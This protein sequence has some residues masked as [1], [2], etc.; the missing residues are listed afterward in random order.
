MLALTTDFILIE[1]ASEIWRSLSFQ[2]G[3]NA[4]I[5]T[6]GVTFLGAA[7]GL[8]GCFTV[9]RKRA[10]MSDALAH[11]ALPG[12]ALTFIIV[13]SLGADARNLIVLLLGA[14]LSASLGIICVQFISRK[15][16]LTE[17]SA[18]GAVLSVFFGAGIV[19]LSYIQNMGTAQAAGLQTFIYGQ[20]AALRLSDMFLTICL[21]FLAVA[22]CVLLL[23]EFRLVCFDPEFA[24]SQGW[25]VNLIDLIM[26]GL[27]ILII[28]IGLQSVGL[29]LIV[30]LLVIPPATARFWTEDLKVMLVIS[31]VCGALSAYIGTNLSTIIP[32]LP[33]GAVIVVSAG[34]LF[35][36]SL[37][38][39]PQRG[40][41]ATALRNLALR[42]KV[43][44]DHILRAAYEIAEQN[45]D[46]SGEISLDRVRPLKDWSNYSRKVLLLV[47]RF[48]NLIR[49][50]F[51]GRA[52]FLTPHGL[53][54]AIE[55]VRNHRLWEEYLLHYSGISAS[56]VDFSADFVE[57][58]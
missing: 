46:L 32:H 47:A 44:E 23:K 17:D 24:A 12:L 2:A 10:L 58:I 54:R 22:V 16:R 6:L 50:D 43:S 49:V 56:H 37:L 9:L 8:L 29:I 1:S 14:A 40:L 36:T 48:R 11:S 28:V 55:L 27:L 4:S 41:I 45:G 25:R 35:V 19:L 13:T 30:A 52:I 38:I 15:T 33:T 21:T 34:C 51:V 53:R 57:H 18:I 7:S 20:A 26:M 3:Y 42:V 39:A 5:V 31:S